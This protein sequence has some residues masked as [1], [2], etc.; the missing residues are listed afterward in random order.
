MHLAKFTQ[1]VL[2]RGATIDL[3]WPDL[4]AIAAL[5]ALF[6]ASALARFRRTLARA[7]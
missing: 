6:L 2:C 4:V 7:Q 3:V 5:G 1:S